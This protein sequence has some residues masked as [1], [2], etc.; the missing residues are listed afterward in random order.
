MARIFISCREITLSAGSEPGADAL[1]RFNKF[2]QRQRSLPPS[3]AAIGKSVHRAIIRIGTCLL[4]KQSA[5]RDS[6][7]HRVLSIPSTGPVSIIA[8]IT[9]SSGSSGD[10]G[11]ATSALL[12]NPIGVAIASDGTIYIEDSNNNTG[13]TQ[14]NRIRKVDT[15]GNISTVAQTMSDS[16]AIAPDNSLYVGTPGKTIFKISPSGNTTQVAGNGVETDSG[17]GGPAT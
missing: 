10:G 11:P 6:G 13:D 3:E 5:I 1:C 12:N 15:Q 17:D 8:G 16:I 4:G 7:N 14:N 9:G 2:E